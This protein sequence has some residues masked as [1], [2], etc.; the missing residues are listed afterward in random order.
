MLGSGSQGIVSLV[1]L[2]DEE[3]KESKE[4]KDKFLV[5][6]ELIDPKYRYLAQNECKIL[7]HLKKTCA[8]DIICLV[9]CDE[10]G[11][12][13]LLEY[14]DGYI[15]LFD[16]IVLPEYRNVDFSLVYEIARRAI[17]GLIRLH[18]LGVA[19]FDIKPENIIVNPSNDRIKYIDFG[20]AC[21]EEKCLLS[22]KGTQSY[23]APEL[24]QNPKSSSS[25]FKRVKQADIWSLGQTLFAL[26]AG[27]TFT[28]FPEFK[29]FLSS[30]I[31]KKRETLTG[32]DLWWIWNKD[33]DE[34]PISPEGLLPIGTF[35]ST[36]SRAKIFKKAYPDDYVWLML[37]IQSMLN[38]FPEK[39]KLF[40]LPPWPPSA[41][42]VRTEQKEVVDD[43]L[44]SSPILPPIFKSPTMWTEFP[45]ISQPE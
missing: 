40:S 7:T 31:K 5:L 22:K 20:M 39:R 11:D 2:V 42:R 18:D 12:N 44:P 1:Q 30:Y 36:S 26:V 14:M 13:I 17:D 15:D 45:A 43:T 6:K 25:D 23:M 29:S 33:L 24:F 27:N 8:D 38:Y 19:I 21:L 4:S 37:T 34:L 41:P 28:N 3:D 32:E 10:D 9:H 16:F 35:A